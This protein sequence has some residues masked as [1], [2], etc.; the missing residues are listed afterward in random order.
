[1]PSRQGCSFFLII[2]TAG[3]YT[4]WSTSSSSIRVYHYLL[5]EHHPMTFR[6]IW[7]QGNI[8]HPHH[9]SHNGPYLHWG[10][11]LVGWVYNCWRRRPAIPV[12]PTR[13]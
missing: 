10:Y 4:T 12:A 8:V 11:I 9:E 1:V 13:P 7:Y 5:V 2:Y 3:S 6:P